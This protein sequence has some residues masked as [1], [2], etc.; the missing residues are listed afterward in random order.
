MRPD[1]TY[2][3]KATVSS[4]NNSSKF[5]IGL[6]SGESVTTLATVSVPQTADNNWDTYRVIEGKISKELPEGKQIIRITITGSYCNIDKLELICTSNGIDDI[7]NHNQPR[8][9]YN[10]AGQ[11]MNALQ[12]GINIVDGKKIMVK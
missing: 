10:L 8:Q 12:R 7:T 5:T 11:R 6:S 1:G 3:Y 4:G 9:L 2:S